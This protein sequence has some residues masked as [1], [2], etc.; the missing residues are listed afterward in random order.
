MYC[1]LGPFGL[2]LAFAVNGVDELF[3]HFSDISLQSPATLPTIL[4]VSFG[5]IP[6]VLSPAESDRLIIK[7]NLPLRI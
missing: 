7:P 2:L 6:S 3:Y 1:E 4:P 5:S